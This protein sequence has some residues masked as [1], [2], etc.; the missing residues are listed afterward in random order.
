M[1][2]LY[3]VILFIVF[4]SLLAYC[5]HSG[6]ERMDKSN[7]V[8]SNN[9]MIKGR[10]LDIKIS[11]NH[12]FGILLLKV[13]SANIR[14]F[15]DTQLQGG[16]Y[17]YKIKNGRAEI[18]LN[19]P[20]GLQNGDEAIVDSDKKTVFYHYKAE[21]RHAESNLLVVDDPY[22]IEYVKENTVFK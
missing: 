9:L 10:I 20:D 2:Y 12:N 21:N 4:V 17:P 15:V 14:K 13:D 6:E 22:N 11:G 5:Y 7:Q 16:I 1:K 18:Y 19:V 8:M 3:L